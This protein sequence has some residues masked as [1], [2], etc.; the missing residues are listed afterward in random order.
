M[1]ITIYRGILRKKPTCSKA[2]IASAGCPLRCFWSF[3]ATCRATF[4]GASKV[5]IHFSGTLWGS[6][7]G[8]MFHTDPYYWFQKKADRPVL[9]CL[10][11]VLFLKFCICVKTAHRK[12]QSLERSDFGWTAPPHALSG[13]CGRGPWCELWD[14]CSWSSS[15]CRYTTS[16]CRIIFLHNR[17]GLFELGLWRCPSYGTKCI[18]HL[19]RCLAYRWIHPPNMYDICTYAQEIDIALWLSFLM[20][21]TISSLML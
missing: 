17:L 16:R 11:H 2:F 8:S 1:S 18:L 10:V 15:A 4:P 13:V 14:T 21:N 12:R 3:G 7:L 20:V 5:T 9:L 6:K 19:N